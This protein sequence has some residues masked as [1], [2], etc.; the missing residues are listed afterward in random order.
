MWG[1]FTLG[2]LLLLEI[3]IQLRANSQQENLMMNKQRNS[4]R[5]RLNTHDHRLQCKTFTLQDSAADEDHRPEH[6]GECGRAPRGSGCSQNS[7]YIK[8]VLVPIKP[9]P[10]LPYTPP[11]KQT[12][13]TFFF[14]MQLFTMF[15]LLNSK[16]NQDSRHFIR[17]LGHVHHYHS[18][19]WATSVFTDQIQRR[20]K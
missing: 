13:E 12:D 9:L 3:Q 17:A 20:K 2:G 19:Y 18:F 10:K 7:H 1:F 4:V 6:T 5:W 14:L 15:S 8:D 11:L 16:Q